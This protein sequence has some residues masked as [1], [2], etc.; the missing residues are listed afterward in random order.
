LEESKI[1][2]RVVIEL[3]DKELP[4]TCENFRQLCTGENKKGLSYKHKTI[5]RVIPEFA[6]EGGDVSAVMDGKGG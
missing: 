3:F 5:Y 6:M 4:D 2:G 1:K